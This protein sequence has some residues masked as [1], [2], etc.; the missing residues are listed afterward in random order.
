MKLET[1][2]VLAM[3]IIAI[4]F[5]LFYLILPHIAG[6]IGTSFCLFVFISLIREHFKHEID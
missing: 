1:N 4:F 3:I 6:I 5:I 2:I